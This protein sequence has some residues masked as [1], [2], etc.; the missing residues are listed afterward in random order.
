MNEL[1][2]PKF[3]PAFGPL[4]NSPL[5][6]RQPRR[7]CANHC[8]PR[9]RHAYENAEGRFGYLLGG[10]T[11][12]SAAPFEGCDV[13]SN[14]FPGDHEIDVWGSLPFPTLPR[15]VWPRLRWQ[16]APASSNLSYVSTTT[17]VCTRDSQP[18]EDP[19]SVSPRQPE[20]VHPFET[21]G[22]DER[23]CVLGHLLYRGRR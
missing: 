15:T 11:L 17:F 6:V 23:D 12:A 13:N 16:F 3:R 10:V 20:E 21:H 9:E 19:P 8:R 1:R 7:S 14:P 2:A 18:D 5:H 4:S 22:L